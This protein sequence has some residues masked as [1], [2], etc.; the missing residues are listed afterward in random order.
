MDKIYIYVRSERIYKM[1]PGKSAYIDAILGS[2]VENGETVLTLYMDEQDCFLEGSKFMK[3]DPS[4]KK[5]VI[6]GSMPYASLIANTYILEEKGV[7]V[8]FEKGLLDV[9]NIDKYRPSDF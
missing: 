9:G 7:T 6:I 5:I 2:L 1:K 3:L 8:T 4:L